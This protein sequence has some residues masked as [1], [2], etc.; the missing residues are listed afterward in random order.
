MIGRDR[1]KTCRGLGQDKDRV[2]RRHGKD[3]GLGKDKGRTDKSLGKTRDRTG[4]RKDRTGK[5][6][7]VMLIT[8][9]KVDYCGSDR[10]NTRIQFWLFIP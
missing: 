8:I 9:G 5:T 7:I 4:R 3:R 10:I 1:G 6:M 2:E